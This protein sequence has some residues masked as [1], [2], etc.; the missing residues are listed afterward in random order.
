MKKKILSILL[1]V[2]L[3]ASLFP[4]AAF[5][6]DATPKSETAYIS[7]NS[8]GSVASAYIINAFDVGSDGGIIDYG[9]YNEIK[10]LTDTSAISN[11]GDRITAE[12]ESGTF[13]YQG[14]LTQ[15]TL[16]WDISIEYFLDGSKINA[17]ELAGK[18]GAFELLIHI[19]KG[20][21]KYKAFY[22]SYMMQISL[23][24]NKD[25]CANIQSETASINVVGKTA[26]ISFTHSMN[27]E[28][29]YSLMANV[30]DF[31]M[32]AIQFRAVAMNIGLDIN[33]DSADGIF[34]DFTSLTDGVGTLN[35][36]AGKLADGSNSFNDGM[37]SMSSKTN[38][39]AVNVNTLYLNAK[40]LNEAAVLFG[41]GLGGVSDL[42][43]LPEKVV[44]LQQAAAQIATASA[45]FSEQLTVYCSGIS[46]LAEASTG[47]SQSISSFNE[48]TAAVPEPDA[49]LVAYAQSLLNSNDPQQKA[50]AAAF[51]AQNTALSE[52]KAG[53]NS[54]D[55]SYN[56]FD[57][58]LQTAAASGVKLSEG[59]LAL[60]ASIKQLSD[61]LSQMADAL[62]SFN[63]DNITKLQ[64]SYAQLQNGINGIYN[65]LGT[66]NTAV[67]DELVPGISTMASSY[68]TL[69][70]GMSKLADAIS[71]MDESVAELPDTLR[72]KANELLGSYTSSDNTIT[73]FVSD[74][75]TVESVL[76]VMQTEEIVKPVVVVQETTSVRKPENFW[77]RLLNLFG[78]FKS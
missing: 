34:G 31:E 23:S 51:L 77:E 25:L 1:T 32:S 46:A 15:T 68:K 19:K 69:N 8:D 30:H 38:D 39:F 16:P 43:S 61:G 36:N 24:L 73:S 42:G 35:E 78:L 14:T 44:A 3:I 56:Q 6:A 18:S 11:N 10:N 13:Y 28:A 55:G 67:S 57:T 50:L 64:S 59:Y 53:I 75:N 60:N 33:F 40:K 54:L 74:K 58:K 4:Q 7:L 70:D 37:Q 72:E 9:D 71:Q 41:N 62:N 63:A 65:A 76:F 22:E 45:G 17:N 29:T 20:D 21:T 48:K 66:I 47:I 49:A 52:I 2:V 5:A 26:S 12:A 27:K